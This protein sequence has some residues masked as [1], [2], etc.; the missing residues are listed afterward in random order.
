MGPRLLCHPLRETKES[1]LR[2][3][4][5][6]RKSATT[7]SRSLPMN[8]LVIAID[9]PAGAGKSTVARLVAQRLGYLYIDSGA[10]YRAVAL[11]ALRS[12]V[13]LDDPAALGRIADATRVE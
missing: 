10:M 9:G 6:K 11:Q 7:S 2:L 5:L 12:G 8:S 1:A 3:G 4:N 13:D